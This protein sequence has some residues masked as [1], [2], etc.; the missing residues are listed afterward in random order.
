MALPSEVNMSMGTI[1]AIGVSSAS[2][3]S[4]SRPSAKTTCPASVGLM[5]PILSDRA[6]ES[7]PI[8]ALTSG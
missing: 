7:V 5:Q 1:R 6:P 4:P 3:E 2:V 8:V